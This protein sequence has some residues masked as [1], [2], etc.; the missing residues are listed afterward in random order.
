MGGGWRRGLGVKL[1][2]SGGSPQHDQLIASFRFSV[3][4][5]LVELKSGPSDLLWSPYVL[6]AS[7]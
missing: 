4:S 5:V 7:N 6:I 1:A 2:V 3:V